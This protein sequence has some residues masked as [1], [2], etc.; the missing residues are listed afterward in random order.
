[1]NTREFADSFRPYVNAVRERMAKCGYGAAGN[2]YEASVALGIALA[3]KNTFSET[4]R[5]IRGRIQD[6]PHWYVRVD[7]AV[8]AFYLDPTSEQFD[9]IPAFEEYEAGEREPM[10]L[11]TIA[12]LL[13]DH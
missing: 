2:C 6:T 3:A 13:R 10:D 12:L 5:L 11:T 7:T 4:V 8:G 9:E 1:M